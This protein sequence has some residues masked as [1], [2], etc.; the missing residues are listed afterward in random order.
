LIEINFCVSHQ[1]LIG[2][3]I[4]ARKR[5]LFEYLHFIV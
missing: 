2:L 4:Q 1:F 5:N 3:N